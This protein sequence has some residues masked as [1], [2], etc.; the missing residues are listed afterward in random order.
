[1]ILRRCARFL[2]KRPKKAFKHLCREFP[3]F[4][5]KCWSCASRK[6]CKSTRWRA[7]SAFPSRPWS[8]GCIAAS[9][10]F[11]ERFREA[12]QHERKH[13]PTRPAIDRT[14]PRGRHVRYRPQLAACASRRMRLLRRACAPDRPRL[15]NAADCGH[16][17]SGRSCQPYA[18]PCAL[19][20]PG[21]A[22]ART[23]APRAVAGLQR[24][25][26]FWRRQRAIRV[27][28]VSMARPAHRSSQAGLG[29]WIWSVVV[30]SGAVCRGGAADGSF[31][32]G[33][34]SRLDQ[35]GKLTA[36]RGER[37]ECLTTSNA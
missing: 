36:T 11:A 30:N 10:R 31:A 4:I 7:C 17:P 25:V 2:A 27:E 33:R 13:A 37:K 26:D 12:P 21:I 1:M 15:A 3:P 23:E 34:A 6:N 19:A 9:K 14:S 8:R 24:V 29:S 5:V 20:R 35:S 28:L 16:F 32:K 22:R 18:I